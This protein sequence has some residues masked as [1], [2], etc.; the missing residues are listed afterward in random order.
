MNGRLQTETVD[1]RSDLL[2]TMKLHQNGFERIQIQVRS[3]PEMFLLG[4]VLALEP[5]PVSH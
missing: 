1:L 5:F 3:F 2:S 4:E